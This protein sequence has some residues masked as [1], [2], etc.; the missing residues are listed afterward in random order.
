MFGN[1]DTK[2]F[3][4]TLSRTKLQRLVDAARP[5][6]GFGQDGRIRVRDE[7]R[8]KRNEREKRE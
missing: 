4:R 2:T 8:V 7:V 5:H 3:S 1:R 6:S